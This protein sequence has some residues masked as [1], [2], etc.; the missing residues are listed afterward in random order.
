MRRRINLRGLILLIGMISLRNSKCSISKFLMNFI[1][2]SKVMRRCPKERRLPKDW[3]LV[4]ETSF[5]SV[6]GI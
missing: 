2:I 1:N 4:E 5:T 3:L 6:I